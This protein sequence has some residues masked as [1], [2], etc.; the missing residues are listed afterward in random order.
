MTSFFIYK[1]IEYG[2]VIGFFSYVIY[3][4]EYGTVVE[5]L[6]IYKTIEYDTVRF[7]IRIVIECSY[8]AESDNGHETHSDR[9]ISS[10]GIAGYNR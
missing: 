9:Y 5:F 10:D 6:L 2:T 7:H 4:N 8:R 1:T 3:T